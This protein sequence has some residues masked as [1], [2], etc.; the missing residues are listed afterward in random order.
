MSSIF[1]KYNQLKINKDKIK[2]T[3]PKDAKTQEDSELQQNHTEI[4]WRFF[5]F[6][7]DEKIVKKVEI[8]IKRPNE[9]RC[10]Y[11]KNGNIIDTDVPKMYDK[12]VMEEYY[13]YSKN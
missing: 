7:I 12:F 9:A 11:D 2:E 10:Y 6:I 5:K 3:I 13:H 1:T 4:R 8:S